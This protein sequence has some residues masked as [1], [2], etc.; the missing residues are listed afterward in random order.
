MTIRTVKDA[1]NGEIRV[2]VVNRSHAVPSNSRPS[3]T[4]KAIGLH[5]VL[6]LFTSIPAIAALPGI[7]LCQIDHIIGALAVRL[8]IQHENW[9]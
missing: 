7:V 5:T 6:I 1:A 3:R 9:I 8:P 4:C 2:A